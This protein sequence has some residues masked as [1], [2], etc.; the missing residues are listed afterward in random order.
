MLSNKSPVQ[1]TYLGIT[2]TNNLYWY[3]HI[4]ITNIANKANSTSL[5]AFLQRNLSQC[6]QSVKS[7]CYNTYVRPIVEYA[8]FIWSPHLLSDI[9]R[10]E[11]VQHRSAR[12]RAAKRTFGAQGKVLK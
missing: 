9:N 8:S 11:M 1:S 6:Q 2:I 7:T 5:R 4:N 3:E 12:F 10:I